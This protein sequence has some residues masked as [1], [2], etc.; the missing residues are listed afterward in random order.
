LGGGKYMT[1]KN[2]SFISGSASDPKSNS[3]SSGA[4]DTVLNSGLNSE[5]NSDEAAFQ[6][7]SRVR[8][9]LSLVLKV[10][11]ACGLIAWLISRDII[12]FDGFRKLASPQFVFV[13]ISF[14]FVQIFLNNFRWIILLRSQRFSAGVFETLSLN[15]IS[16]FFSFAMPGGVGGDVVRG[17]YLAKKNPGRR[18]AAL[19]T[20]FMDRLFGFFSMITIAFSAIA[21]NWSVVSKVPELQ[22]VAL[23]V[24]LLFLG[25][26]SFFAISLSHRAQ[27]LIPNIQIL[28]KIA[29]AFLTYRQSLR[30]LFFAF[31]VSI[32]V[33][34][35][36]IGFF[37]Y[38]SQQMTGDQVPIE[39]LIFLTPLAIVLQALPI[40]PGGVGVGQ[41]ALYFLFKLYLGHESQVG[42][43]AMTVMQVVQFGFG[44]IGAILYL[45]MR[46]QVSEK[47]T[48]INDSISNAAV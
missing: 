15:L 33:Q 7:T 18:T 23:S 13:A 32:L 36:I 25:F 41:A 11:I 38:V 37:I 40:S 19:T 8:S 28:R 44:L 29:A 4:R 35:L 2:S 20:I 10:G 9:I 14:V 1:D 46:P 31:S 30:A 39:S 12:N 17:Y 6:K 26:I 42:P 24:S 43:T 5:V 27:R 34:L 22:A 45:R 21:L 16:L 47:N 3:A 48:S